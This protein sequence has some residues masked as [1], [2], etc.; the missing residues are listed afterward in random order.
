MRPEVTGYAIPRRYRY[1]LPDADIFP[2]EK[3]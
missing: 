3:K 2:T 1:I